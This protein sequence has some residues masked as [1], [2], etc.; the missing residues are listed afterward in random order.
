MLEPWNAP[1]RPADSCGPEPPRNV[2]RP[3]G[4]A[5]RAFSEM[6]GRFTDGSSCDCQTP[7]FVD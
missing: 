2:R 6:V 5:D 7:V 1:S 3:F 4:V